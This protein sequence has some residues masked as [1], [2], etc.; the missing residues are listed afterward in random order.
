MPMYQSSP[1]GAATGAHCVV[2]LIGPI[3]ADVSA[4]EQILVT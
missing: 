4:E 3:V 1:L 2:A